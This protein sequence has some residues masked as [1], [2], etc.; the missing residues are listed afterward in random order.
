MP[1]GCS[2]AQSRV[3]LILIAST[4]KI[5]ISGHPTG[6]SGIEFHYKGPDISYLLNTE[7]E[8]KLN[9]EKM[10]MLSK[11]CLLLVIF[12]KILQLVWNVA[13]TKRFSVIM[14]ASLAKFYLDLH[15]DN[16]Q[17]ECRLSFTIFLPAD[18]T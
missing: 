2:H 5:N 11:I 17:E 7:E 8:R 12:P 15:A 1:L 14:V 18:I 6:A 13:F 9:A 16:T 4:S 10:K 3:K